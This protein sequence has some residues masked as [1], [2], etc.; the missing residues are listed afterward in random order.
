MVS[1]RYPRI[2]P[3]CR[4][5]ARHGSGSAISWPREGDSRKVC[6]NRI[7]M[8]SEPPLLVDSVRGVLCVWILLWASV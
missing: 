1:R 3:A 2:L 5:T 6:T 8:F 4:C 7:I